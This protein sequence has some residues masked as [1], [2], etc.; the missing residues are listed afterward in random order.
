MKT[1]SFL[2]IIFWLYYPL[3]GNAQATMEIA[4]QEMA[5]PF[6]YHIRLPHLFESTVYISR[7]VLVKN[8]LSDEILQDK[9][10]V[11]EAFGQEDQR[12]V[13]VDLIQDGT[14]VAVRMNGGEHSTMWTGSSI[15]ELHFE[16][17]I[18]GD[19]IQGKLSTD[20]EL[21]VFNKEHVKWKISAEIKRKTDVKILN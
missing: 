15:P 19:Q 3:V 21:S 9:W 1:L 10:A 2:I 14:V 5:L 20:P 16:G 18:G 13:L 8:P 11:L 17:A 7:V 6:V 4:G 12:G